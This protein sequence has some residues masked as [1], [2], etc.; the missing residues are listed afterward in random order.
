MSNG[1]KYFGIDGFE[2]INKQLGLKRKETNENA[3][4]EQK[5][6]I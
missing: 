3:Y 6:K 4:D 5:R 2:E 1:R